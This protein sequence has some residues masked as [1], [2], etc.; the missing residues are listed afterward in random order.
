MRRA[1]MTLAVGLGLLPL[2]SSRIEID[3]M[4]LIHPDILLEITTSGQTNWQMTP[5]PSAARVPKPS[6]ASVKIVGN[7]ME[8]KSPIDNRAHP[9]AG[10]LESAEKVS[11]AMTVAAAQANTLPGA[12]K[13]ST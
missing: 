9:E 7:M 6:L 4:I 5:E 3:R 2:L 10:P 13:R 11:N 1:R 8:L 12:N